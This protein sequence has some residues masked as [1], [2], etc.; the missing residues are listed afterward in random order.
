[1]GL[2]L[3]CLSSLDCYLLIC[4]FFWLVLYVLM[5]LVYICLAVTLRYLVFFFFKY[6]INNL[7]CLLIARTQLC[8][9]INEGSVIFFYVRSSGNFL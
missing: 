4:S 5:F 8:G 7:R 1:M 6:M 9:G 2:T 3:S